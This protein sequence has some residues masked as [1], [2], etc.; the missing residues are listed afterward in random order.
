M[1]VKLVFWTRGVSDTRDTVSGVGWVTV[2]RQRDAVR[3]AWEIDTFGQS[4]IDKARA[5]GVLARGPGASHYPSGHVAASG[6]GV[7]VEYASGYRREVRV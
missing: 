5:A 7:T 4:A 6:H 2:V 3:M 1:N